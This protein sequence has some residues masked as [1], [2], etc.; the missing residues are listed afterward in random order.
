MNRYLLSLLLVSCAPKDLAVSLETL[1]DQPPSLPAPEADVYA[2]GAGKITDAAVA[3]LAKA[4]QWDEALSGAAGAIA[5]A[6]LDG[7]EPSTW[8]ARWASYR[9]GYPHNLIDLRV[10]RGDIGQVPTEL[11]SDLAGLDARLDVGLARARGYELDTWVLLTA[12]VDVG[13]GPF[14]RVVSVG[15]TITLEVDEPAGV[16]VQW[17]APSGLLDRVALAEHSEFTLGEEGEWWLQL[18]RPTAPARAENPGDPVH[19]MM[20]VPVMVGF[21]TP[22]VAPMV[23]WDAAGGV[24]SGVTALREEFDVAPPTVDPILESVARAR[25]RAEVDPSVSDSF[26]DVA[27]IGVGA[28][29]LFTG[30]PPEGQCGGVLVCSV[31]S[32]TTDA[33]DSGLRGCF[34]RWLVDGTARSVLV[35]ERCDLMGV[36]KVETSSA[37]YTIVVLGQSEG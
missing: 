16:E 5:M 10:Y 21:E 11:G 33:D 2:R 8:T 27:E 15:E 12:R 19:D 35:D 6:I 22:D 29:G 20:S 32:E 37:Q 28:V 17:V 1:A 14:A 23:D 13:I 30:A 3:E 7:E 24:L 36:S 4:L 25:A 31:W 18:L 26:D 9:A 34:E